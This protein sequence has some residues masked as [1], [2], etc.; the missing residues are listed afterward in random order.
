[1]VLIESWHADLQLLKQKN[2]KDNGSFSRTSNTSA[3]A[4]VPKE[5]S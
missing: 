3:N 5:A 1:M 4:D 2:N